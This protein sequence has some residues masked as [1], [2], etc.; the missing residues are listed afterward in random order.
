M[1]NL[2][3]FLSRYGGFLSFLVLE[4]TALYL[5]I[6]FN[7]PQREIFLHSAQYYSGWMLDRSARFRE[8]TTA[9]ET[10]DSLAQENARLYTRLYHQLATSQ[11]ESAPD[12]TIIDFDFLPAR[13][14]KNSIHL[15]NNNLTL[16]KG[17]E[18]GISPGM[19]VMLPR[20]VLGIVRS[21]SS[22]FCMVMS[23]LNARSFISATVERTGALGTL[24]WDGQDPSR[25][26]LTEVP[27]HLEI[28]SGDTVTTS[29]H[30]V[31]F[32]AGIP[33]GTI[34]RFEVPS[35]SNSFVIEVRLF[36]DLT[37]VQWA[38]IIRHPHWAELQ[39]LESEER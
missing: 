37:R 6:R 10:A 38:Y 25:L 22:R 33:I 39:A 31:I 19:G 20:G 5:I 34:T 12:S 11:P 26:L 18:D 35:G 4:I 13:I 2:L 23:V 28:A 27:K 16:D 9:S 14:I 1:I 21:C 15:L 32:P 3:Y 17:T 7:Q 24:T 8:Y 36:E 29:N 30:S